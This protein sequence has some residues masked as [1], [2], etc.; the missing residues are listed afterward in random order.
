M[1]HE[2]VLSFDYPSETA[3]KV[4]ER[5]LRPEVGDIDD[6]RSRATV[7]R[8]GRELGIIIEARDLAALRAGVNTWCSLV[9]V[10]EQAGGAVKSS[11][12]A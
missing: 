10:A 6:D 1:I 3:A 8:A 11:G 2:V 7:D 5:S 12:T 4:V 9:S